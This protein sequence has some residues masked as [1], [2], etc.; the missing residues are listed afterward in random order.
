MTIREFVATIKNNLSSLQLDS[1]ISSEFIYST[2]VGIASFFIKRESESR[3]LFK[4][5]SIF[6]KLPCVEFQET[7]LAECGVDLGCRTI[8]RSKKPLPKLF[9]SN[10]GSLIQVFNILRNK[11]YKEISATQYKN[12]SR[13][14]Y[15]PKNTKYFWIEND[16]L[17]IPDSEVEILIVLGLFANPEEIINFTGEC[18]KVLDFAF[19][20]PDYL[21][22]P[23]IE[24]TIKQLSIKLQI[25]K[26]EDSNL[27]NLDKN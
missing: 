11:D 12:I 2:A 10:F 24:Q 17:Y 7:S 3:K 5:T 21:L 8:M 6:Y 20:A 16:Y 13:Q 9:L 18:T 26:D 19:P 25:P 4:N 15:K 22:Q 1:K 23:I 14:K 27:N